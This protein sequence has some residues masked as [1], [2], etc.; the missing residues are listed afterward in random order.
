ML[1]TYKISHIEKYV[2]TQKQL[3]DYFN[4]GFIHIN[5]TYTACKLCKSVIVIFRPSGCGMF[6]HSV[7]LEVACHCLWVALQLM[8]RGECGVIVCEK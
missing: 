3:C 2:N 1:L 7:Q 4:T 8:E 6:V 5:Y